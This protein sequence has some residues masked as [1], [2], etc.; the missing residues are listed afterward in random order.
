MNC[1]Q[2]YTRDSAVFVTIDIHTELLMETMMAIVQNLIKKIANWD[3][4]QFVFFGNEQT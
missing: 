3:S 4:F 1:L 2:W